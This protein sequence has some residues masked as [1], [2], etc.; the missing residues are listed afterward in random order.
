MTSKPDPTNPLDDREFVTQLLTF[1]SLEQQTN[2]HD[3]IT[4][5]ESTHVYICCSPRSVYDVC[6]VDR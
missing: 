5:A 4:K 2:M 6:R 1:S 3:S